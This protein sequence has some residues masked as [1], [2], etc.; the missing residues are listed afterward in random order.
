METELGSKLKKALLEKENNISLF[1]WKFPRKLD[2]NKNY[3]QTEIKLV[4]CSIEELE[5]FK[6]HCNSMLY[7]KS[8]DNLGRVYLFKEIQI[9]QLKCGVELF[10]RYSES[11]GTSRV[12]IADTLRAAIKLNGIG[13]LDLKHTVLSD[14]IGVP[15]EY[16]RLPI[17]L[18][19]DGCLDKLGKFDA[20]HLTLSFIIK[21]GLWFTKE[22]QKDL[23]EFD[24]EGKEIDKRDVIKER[25]NLHRNV[26]L[27]LNP[28]GL[29]YTKFRSLVTL[30]SKKYSELTTDQLVTLKSRALYALEDDVKKHIDFWERKIYEIDQVL[31]SKQ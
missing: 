9:Q 13:D 31:K 14:L 19:I 16:R 27:L 12:A 22:E 3:I 30:K 7:N 23:T 25:L 20:R 26:N 28:C 29:T 24:G 21:Q 4:N 2:E 17:E 6:V 10:L 15:V 18:V 5:R 11:I 1:T 8:K